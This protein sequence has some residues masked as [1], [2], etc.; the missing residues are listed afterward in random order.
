MTADGARPEPALDLTHVELDAGDFR[1]AIRGLSIERGQRVGVIGRN[2]CGKTTLLE[3]MLGLRTTTRLEGRML[4]RPIGA[5]ARDP[6]LRARCGVVLQQSE[7]SQYVTVREVLRAHTV[8]YG[9]DWPWLLTRLLLDELL[10]MR[11]RLLSRGQRQRLALYLALA[12]RPGLVLFDE[13]STGLDRRFKD[14]LAHEL[15]RE[16]PE[17]CDT[18]FL[19]VGHSP[20]EIAMCGEFIWLHA[21]RVVDRGNEAQLLDRHVGAHRARV[22]AERESDLDGLDVAM[23]RHPDVRRVIRVDRHTLLM[24]STRPLDLDCA[25]H[26]P[27][28]G[29]VSFE[30]GRTELDELVRVGPRVDTPVPTASLAL[31]P[32]AKEHPCAIN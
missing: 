31:A 16:A 13:P 22:R 8:M 20:D 25:R 2:G 17:L 32:I 30:S 29:W 21:G 28:G 4:G 11:A 1:L 26:S 10:H 19:I 12:H 18:A 7:M 27:P 9:R 5:F 6:A 24:F 14:F 3:A 23:A 15:L